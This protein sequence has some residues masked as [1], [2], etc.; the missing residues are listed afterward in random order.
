MASGGSIRIRPHVVFIGC[1]WKTIRP[2]Y[3][4]VFAKKTLKRRNPL[5]FVIVGRDG[6]QRAEDLG[7]EIKLKSLAQRSVSILLRR[8]SL[9]AARACYRERAI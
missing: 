2:K 9:I 6:N 7:A 3:E 1:P 5:L 8:A 4:R